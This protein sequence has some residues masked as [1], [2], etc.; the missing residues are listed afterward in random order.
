MSYQSHKAAWAL[1]AA[2]CCTLVCIPPASGQAPGEGGIKFQVKGPAE[3]LEMTVNTSRVVEF[4]FDVPRM[5]VNNPDLVRV[6]PISPKS[7]QLSALRAGVTQLN[8]WDSDGNVTSV[9]VVILG[10]VAELD[11]TLKTLFPEA[12]LRLRPLNSSL[13]I[14]G[15]VPKAEMVA[16][17]TRVS[18]PSTVGGRTRAKA[19]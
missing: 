17:I 5:L 3:R 19:V 7:I 4:P 8:V 6:V 16:S 11:M 1:V 15:F 10:D 14:S 9:D 18:R 13:Y 2:V 12:S